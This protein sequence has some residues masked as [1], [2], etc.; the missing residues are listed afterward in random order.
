MANATPLSPPAQP[1]HLN[2][3]PMRTFVILLKR[4]Y[5]REHCLNVRALDITAVRRV[6]F[7]MKG[8]HVV[9]FNLPS[10]P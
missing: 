10:K 6:A 9:G 5:P 8:G 3:T 1:V 7:V 4:F 2:V